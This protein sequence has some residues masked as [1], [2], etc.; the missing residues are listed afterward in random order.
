VRIGSAVKGV[1]LVV[2]WP[3]TGLA[4]G[5]VPSMAPGKRGGSTQGPSQLQFAKA[6]AATLSQQEKNGTADVQQGRVYISGYRHC[7]KLAHAPMRLRRARV[8]GRSFAACAQPLTHVY[9][10]GA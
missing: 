1:V 4:W 7:G 9:T 3:V 10:A 5:A 8:V 2:V 6:S